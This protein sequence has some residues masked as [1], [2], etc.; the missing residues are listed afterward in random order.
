MFSWRAARRCSGLAATA[1]AVGV[2]VP[3][4]A[5][6]D[7]M[8]VG[9]GAPR[10]TASR[11]VTAHPAKVTQQSIPT[12]A[13][14]DRAPAARSAKDS[15]VVAELDA[16]KLAPFSMLGVTW[17]GGL[18]DA[19][20]VVEVRWRSAG[21]WSAW[22]ELH[23]DPAP[24]EGGRSGTEPQWVGTA[25]G[26]QVRVAS[27]AE[28][29]PSG[30]AL[31]TIDPAAP[32]VES[33]G[34]SVD[35]AVAVTPAASVS[36][37]TII[38]RSS[39]GAS[40]AGS[41]DSPIYGSTTRGAVIH[42]TAGTN[43]YTKAQSAAIVKAT[44][45]YHMKSRQWC[46]IGYNFL[47]DKYGQTFEGRAGGVTKP[48]RAAHAG[49]LAVNEETM[50]VSLMGTFDKTTPTAAMETA[51]VNLVSWRFAQYKLPAK[52]TYSLGG[53]TLNRIAGHRNVVGT[54]CPGAVVYSWLSA[55]GG[56]RDLV[57]DRLATG[58]GPSTVGGLAASDEASTAATVSWDA[59][60][61]AAK[62]RVYY[63]TSSSMGSACEPDCRVIT[64]SDL[65]SPS[66]RLTGLKAGSAYYVKV[67]AISAAG[68]T[69]TGW[70]TTP[71]KVQLIDSATNRDVPQG[72]R[73]TS[74][75]TSAITFSWGAVSGAP[76]Y[77]IQLS[78]S[79]SMSGAT[80]YRFYGTSGTVSGLKAGTKYYAKVRTIE[81]DGTNI[82]P[83]SSAVTASTVAAAGS[84]SAV[85]N[86]VN[87]PSSRAITFTG[88]G[89][90][91]GI[92]MSQ[93]GAEGGAR[94]GESYTKI[95]ST[96]YP[97]TAI[98][99]RSGSMR[100]LLSK[101]TT[102]SV[103]VEGRSGLVLRNL[104]SKTTTS[105]PTTVGGKTVI[106]W[107]I[108]ANPANKKQSLLQ[109]R[110]SSTWQTYK[111]MV[112]TGDAQFEASTLRLIMPN[113][114]AVSYRS[115]LRS[116]LPS[117]GSTAR[118]TVNVL[119]IENYTRGV[120]AREMPSSWHAEA[121][122]AQAVAARTYGVRSMSSS[123]YYDICD[124][125]ACQV[126]GGVSAETSATDSAVSGTAGKILT[127][128]GTPAFTQFSSSSGGYTNAG[129]QSYLRAVSDPW[130]N[131]SGNKN[132]SWSISVKASTIEQKY[133][134]VGTL[135]SLQVLSRNGHGDMGGRVASIKLVGSK[136]SKT[137]KGTDARFAFG[138]RSD[139]FGF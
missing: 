13:P 60:P 17:G 93:Y 62:Y 7:G 23:S 79:S 101:D 112:W 18:K 138:L 108:T 104:A 61:G 113:D 129:S 58:G 16:D 89:Y 25:D 130:D 34:T 102:D 137:I 43:T 103:M 67:S 128:G 26:A 77:R 86:T 41:C 78:T 120:V 36:Q 30:L 75:T 27:N 11:P 52:G 122:K 42:H 54:E 84:A 83:Y 119:S 80:Y 127:S 49:N 64:P 20:T 65:G 24:E 110:T 121:L 115:A 116:A 134:T 47:V 100:V 3:A 51:V 9:V 53:L 50:G 33:A 72:L 98:G 90:G 88:H 123:R 95:L 118:N 107:N 21:T 15:T 14:E 35:P 139:W 131:W 32:A 55:K 76:R 92:G 81:D 69:L 48:V 94:S 135:K 114:S 66:Y 28:A 63:S 4:P 45:A 38:S 73:T 91:H 40:S 97:G 2:L 136:A 46:D 109:Y 99:T 6:A 70:Q 10:T 68:K 59:V 106:R 44:Q 105:L 29:K 125:T 8:E 5:H 39:W 117:S 82:S 57:E 19:D 85:R 12:R 56:L 111:S 126:Y 22:T 96:Y 1:L 132:H 133:P 37:P 124:T 74:A 71:L 87:V 31:S